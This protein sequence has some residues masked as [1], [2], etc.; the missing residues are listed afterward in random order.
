MAPRLDFD[1]IYGVE[2][3]S[4]RELFKLYMVFLAQRM[5]LL[6]NSWSF[7]VAPFNGT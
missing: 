1:M 6:R 4:L 3:W 7:L 5:L 2:I